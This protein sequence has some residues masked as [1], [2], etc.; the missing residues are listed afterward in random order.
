M[1]VIGAM[2]MAIEACGYVV[3]FKKMHKLGWFFVDK[4]WEVDHAHDWF[5]AG[6][7]VCLLQA[8]F[9]TQ[10]LT[11]IDALVGFG[12]KSG[13]IGCHPA[14][15]PTHYD[16]P[17]IKGIGFNQIDGWGHLRADRAGT[18]P[19]IIVV[20]FDAV[21]GAGELVDPAQV[22]EGIVEMHGPRDIA[23]NQHDIV[24]FD[25]AMPLCGDAFGVIA[26][27]RTKD[28]HWFGLG[29]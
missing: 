27:P 22:D 10:Q 28:V 1:P 16:G 21:F 2:Q 18:V 12:V 3:F 13:H 9:H 15:T 6:D 20:A 24:G 26:P 19:P 23:G 29:K 17:N 25:E 5:G 4:W 14:A 8:S 11:C 7:F